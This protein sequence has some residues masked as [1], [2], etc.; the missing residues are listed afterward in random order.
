MG[1]RNWAAAAAS[2]SLV[3]GAS[4]AAAQGAP[5]A[6]APRVFEQAGSWTADFGDDYCR[7]VQSY[8]DGTDTIS[9]GIERITPGPTMRIMLVGDSVSLFRG[10]ERIGLQFL[11]ADAVDPSAF[12]RSQT[13]EGKQLLVLDSVNLWGSP[14]FVQL[15]AADP[16]GAPRADIPAAAP[17]A[18]QVGSEEAEL[19]RAAELEGVLLST[20]LTKPIRIETGS[21]HPVM[22]VLQSCSYDLLSHWGL[23]AEKHRDRQRNAYPPPG[24]IIPDR[25]VPSAERGRLI[26]DFNR[27]RVMVGPEGQ[28][29]SCHIHSPSL[30][31]RVNANICE[32]VMSNARFEPALNADGQPMAGYW[33]APV[34]ALFGPP[35]R[36]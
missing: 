23:D 3:I 28:P 26:G 22:Q 17:D 35:Q 30:S 15:Y 12:A 11:P 6:A 34:L 18:N 24:R 36:R 25:P 9:L 14:Q 19:A 4:N 20:G 1:I 5:Q 2:I 32:E 13:P 10:S 33:T 16:R 8:T 29:L 21:L 27:V 7:L 31:E